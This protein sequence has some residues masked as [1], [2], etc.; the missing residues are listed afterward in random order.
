MG[1][2]AGLFAFE[3]K[4][5]FLYDIMVGGVPVYTSLRDSVMQL[6]QDGTEA[7]SAV[8]AQGKDGVSLRRIIGGFFKKNRFRKKQTLIFT[9]TVY[10]RDYGRNLAAEF[11]L[12]K[13][14]DSVVFEW[15]SRSATYDNAYL[16]DPQKNKHCPLDYFSVKLKIYN[17]LH[18]KEYARLC[19]DCR[20]M[21][22]PQFEK[23]LVETEN[24]GKA[25]AFLKEQLP[26]SYATTVIYQKL[27]AKF[28]KRYKNVQYAV[29]FWGGARENI[30]PVLKNKPQ[31]IELQHGI[32]TSY[33]GGYIY[34]PFV[35]NVKTDFFKRTLLV[36]GEATK[37]LLVENS[38]FEEENIEVIGNPRI[39]KY[40]TIQALENQTR[41]WIVF[42]SQS[43]EQDGTGVDYYKT[44]IATLKGVK[45]EMDKDPFWKDFRLAVKLHPRES[46]NAKAL[47]EKEIEG[48]KVFGNTSQLFEIL[49]QTFVQLT[50]SST[51]LYEA[52]QF[53]APTVSVRYADYHPEAIYGFETWFM[54]DEQSIAEIMQ[55]L[56]DKKQYDEYLEYL[57]TKTKEYM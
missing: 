29:D 9:S 27:F 7:V 11:L 3:N 33:H 31:S 8:Q 4:Y 41:K 34:P 23:V 20:E 26:Q 40:K 15:P 21:L 24:E 45:A 43:Y 10:R 37:R 17:K 30:I 18:K 54:K 13:Y 55:K 44:V 25:V 36:Y 6:L 5:P 16:S 32:I 42:A 28:F 51:T 57:K 48:I 49:N 52:A 50:V 12:D 38:I 47:Y 2:E 14:P 35:K 56:K 19:Q 39:Q 1:K 22:F 53:D 46:E